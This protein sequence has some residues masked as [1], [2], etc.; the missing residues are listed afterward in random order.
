[1]PMAVPK[2]WLNILE[3]NKKLLLFE[4]N[5]IDS[6]INSLVIRCGIRFCSL[7][8]WYSIASRPSSVGIEVHKLPY[9]RNTY[10]CQRLR[11]WIKI[12]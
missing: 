1:M 4:I 7:V 12:L 11:T 2:I 10:R 3:L 8:I 5:S 6:R 9:N